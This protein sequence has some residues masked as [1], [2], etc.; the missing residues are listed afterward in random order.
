MQF[1]R[2]FLIVALNLQTTAGKRGRWLKKHHIFAEC[3][4]NVRYQIRTIPICPE[5]IKIG[6]NVNIST[7]V[8]LMVHDAIHLIYNCLPDKKMKLSEYANPIEIGDNVFVG[9]HSIIMG[10]VKVGSNIIIAAGTV[11]TKDLEDGG[12]YGGIPAKRI[13]NIDDFWKKRETTYYPSIKSNRHV[14]KKEAKECWDY[15]YNSRKQQ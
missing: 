6:N 4:D 7:G 12:I 14:T 3:G 13:G 9:A 11:V 1:R 2:L 5:L 10:G 15:F 8:S